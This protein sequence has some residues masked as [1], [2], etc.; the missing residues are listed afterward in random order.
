MI[1]SRKGIFFSFIS[2]LIIMLLLV[3]FSRMMSPGSSAYLEDSE[4]DQVAI[5]DSNIQFLRQ[6]YL[7][8]MLSFSFR[9]AVS[10]YVSESHDRGALLIDCLNRGPC[11]DDSQELEELKGMLKRHMAMG[12]FSF[13]DIDDSTDLVIDV[14]EGV[15]SRS[16]LGY[17]NH[18]RDIFS[19]EFQMDIDFLHDGSHWPTSEGMLAL[20]EDIIEDGIV[21]DLEI[22]HTNPFSVS[23][24]FTISYEVSM[25]D[26]R[27]SWEFSNESFS[28]VV[29]FTGL[30]DPLYTFGTA[31]AFGQENEFNNTI[32]ED[33]R[34]TRDQDSLVLLY[35]EMKYTASPGLGPSYLQRLINSPNP[36]DCCGIESLVNVRDVLSGS[37]NMSQDLPSDWFMR[38]NVDHMYFYHDTP[39]G[40][41][42][43][44]CEE[45][46]GQTGNQL[47]FFDA[48]TPEQTS[49]GFFN[50]DSFTAENYGF[51]SVF[52]SSLCQFSV[53]CEEDGDC[54]PGDG[55]NDDPE[56]GDENDS[57]NDD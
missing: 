11:E 35:D 57:E 7:R 39:Q 5:A 47:Y 16:I 45:F 27:T 26:D 41:N 33:S 8:D 23:I 51:S 10:S 55:E 17:L 9:N 38:S 52:A 4:H 24:S 20:D 32:R 6:S 48:L 31:E 43:F 46:T 22:T 34:S 53:E 28:V 21:D 1:S 25:H 29:P 13:D 12:S 40:E 56:S 37:D 3:F 14:E 30:V 15:S 2:I 49:S 50:L 44:N 18:I 42:V 36:S 19:S 54:A